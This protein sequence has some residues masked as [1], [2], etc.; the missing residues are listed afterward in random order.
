MK[1]I[2]QYHEIISLPDNLLGMIEQCGRTCYK[3]ENKIGCT[4]PKY[5]SE[6]V[7]FCSGIGVG[8]DDI[9][10]HYHSSHKFT[11]MLRDRGHHAMLEFGDIVVRLVTSRSV[12]AELTRHRMASFAVESQRY[13][14]YKD[15]IEFIRPVWMNWGNITQKEPQSPEWVFL[16]MCEDAEFAYIDL[17]KKG[18]RQEQAREILP[19]CTKTEIILKANVREFRHIFKLR[20]SKKAHPQ[21]R[22]LMTNLLIDLKKQIPVVFDDIGVENG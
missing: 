15:G 20:T 4:M 19:N 16:N 5:A 2:D 6:D 22:S 1:I 3:S 10:C 18:W 11:K 14:N 7:D 17:L 9:E 12:L 8:C 13:V 21:I